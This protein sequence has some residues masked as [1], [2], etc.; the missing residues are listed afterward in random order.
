M[1]QTY[2][3]E[4]TIAKDLL[5]QLLDGWERIN[6]KILENPWPKLFA[7]AK[8]SFNEDFVSKEMFITIS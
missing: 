2:A 6:T 8:L 1:Q 5:Q 3:E 7:M 4:S